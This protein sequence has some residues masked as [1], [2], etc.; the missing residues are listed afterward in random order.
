[1]VMNT[2]DKGFT[3][4]ELLLVIALG[5]L[6]IGTL[7]FMFQVAL[8]TWSTQGSRIG[9]AVSV[10]KAAREMS[11]DLRNANGIGSQNSNEIRFTTNGTTYYIYYLYNASDSY[12]STFTK[13]SYQLKK[14]VLSGNMTGTFTYGSGDLIARD[15]V[16]P[17]VTNL[18]ISAPHVNIDLTAQQGSSV[19]RSVSTV[20]PR[21][22]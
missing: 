18:S 8:D 11:R 10:N 4:L 5:P 9:V 20:L 22:I 1:M 21:N 3:F 13:T 14:A 19:S 15:I 7:T 6:I 2:R 17:P 12:P 16:P